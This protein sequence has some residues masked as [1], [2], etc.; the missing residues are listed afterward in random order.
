V[1][2]SVAAYFVHSLRVLLAALVMVGMAIALAF[3]FGILT[4]VLGVGSPKLLLIGAG[5]MVLI[6]LTGGGYISARYIT[7][8]SLLHATI[9]GALVGLLYVSTS[10]RGTGDY[11]TGLWIFG[12]EA[13][14]SGGIFA[15]LGAVI[16]RRNRMPPNQRL[17]RP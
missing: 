8:N 4:G 13:V 10:A 9:A 17:E 6:A 2:T 12:S 3:L 5:L 16:A 1:S 11:I 14:T 15:A 7:Q